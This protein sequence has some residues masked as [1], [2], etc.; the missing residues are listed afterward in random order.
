[1][2]GPLVTYRVAK[3]GEAIINPTLVVEV[4]SESTEKY[5]RG[6]KFSHYMKLPSLQEYVL[7]AQD[8]RRIEVFRRPERGHWA[9]EV[10]TAGQSLL[11]HGQPISID[12]VYS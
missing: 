7:V 10:A 5:D 4:L 12:A 8:E 3:L 2:C 9:F 11:L 6:E 1:M